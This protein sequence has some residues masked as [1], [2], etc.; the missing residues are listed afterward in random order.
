MKVIRRLF[1]LLILSALLLTAGVS[2]CAAADVKTPPSLEAGIYEISKYG[3]LIL[4]IGAESMTGLGYEPGDVISVKIGDA[5]MEMPIGTN[6]A[7]VDSGE[8]ICCFKAGSDGITA[9]VLAINA[10]DLTTAMGIAE[11][12]TIDA[13]PGYEWVYAEGF[14][15]DTSAAIS[16]VQKQG[17]AQEYAMHQH[18][19]TRTNKRQ[20]YAHLDDAAFANFRA[21]ETGG[22]G[23]GT[24]YRSSSPISPAL[25]RNR[26][27]DEALLQSLVRTVIN[28]S[29]SEEAM[30]QYSDFALTH[31]AE[32]D[33][34]A[35]NM[36][37]NVLG[38]SFRQKLAEG[39]R[40]MAA[41]DGPYL[42]HCKEGK[43]R[44]GFAAAVLSC[45]M[46]ADAD[47]IAADY[48]LTYYN[49]YG[50]EPETKEYEEIAR[51][52]LESMLAKAF[53]IP[54]IRDEDVS[55]QSCAESYLEGIGMTAEE[56]AMLK[57]KLAE[58][59]GGLISPARL[60]TD[61]DSR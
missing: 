55:L 5:E 54:S 39:F 6:Y 16:M 14:D 25:N 51:S 35:L 19:G 30:R 47:E 53:G 42:I 3:N 27:A 34:I 49:Y 21:V 36:D 12:R 45:L 58:D 7:D 31:Y 10:G 4:A 18:S 50:I 29:D 46:G 43:D 61:R 28:M 1:A 52:N 57:E 23:K 56:I 20:D 32:C 44:T 8:P 41:H 40:Y 9:V 11:R 33:I 15:E 38:E 22:M 13:E 26:E 17:Y 59:Y 2:P 60:T 24:L 37:M 48:M